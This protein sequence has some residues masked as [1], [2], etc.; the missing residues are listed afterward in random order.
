MSGLV[1]VADWLSLSIHSSNA[2]A[3]ARACQWASLALA[4][5]HSPNMSHPVTMAEW[6]ST[7]G[8]QSSASS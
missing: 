7:S 3:A 5:S 4:S 6:T 1:L 8:L 2:V